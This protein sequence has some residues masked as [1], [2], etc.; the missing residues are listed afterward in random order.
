MGLMEGVV[1]FAVLDLYDMFAYVCT[2]F[3]QC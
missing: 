2:I 1:M 3:L